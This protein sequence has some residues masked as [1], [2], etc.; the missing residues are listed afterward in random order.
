[1]DS[2]FS[3][4]MNRAIEHAGHADAKIAPPLREGLAH[5]HPAKACTPIAAIGEVLGQVNRALDGTA[6]AGV[7]LIPSGR[8]RKRGRGATGPI[9]LLAPL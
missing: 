6:Q 4:I 3:S 7:I 9:G 2:S 1:M 8:R 5:H